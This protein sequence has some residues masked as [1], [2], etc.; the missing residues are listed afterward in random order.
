[1]S[2]PHESA[3]SLMRLYDLRREEKMREARTW[4]VRSFNPKSVQDIA[5]IMKTPEYTFFRMVVGYWDMAASFV[6]HGAID[7]EMFRAVS[8]EMLAAY[9]KVEHMID[10]IREGLGLAD[11]L[12]HVEQVAADWPGAEERMAGM[13]E[14]FHGLAAASE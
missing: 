12:T 7:P 4:V 1:M 10:E 5:E 9:C 6:V 13:R 14:Y 2:T 11:L 8:G 3:Q